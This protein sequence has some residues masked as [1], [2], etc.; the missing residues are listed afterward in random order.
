MPAKTSSKASSKGAAAAK[1]SES[2]ADNATVKIGGRVSLAQVEKACSAL[3]AHR[4]RSRTNAGGN[5]ASNDLPLDG[6]DDEE[7][8]GARSN[9]SDVVWMQI[10][11]KALN[12][13][14]PAKPIRLPTPYPIYAPS[15]SICLITA[16]PQRTYKDL[17]V[18]QKLTQVKRVVGVTKLK[19]KFAPYEARR[20]LMNDHDLFLAD[21]RIIPMLPKLLGKKWMN[22]RKSPIPVQL[23]KTKDGKVRKE[24]ESALASTFYHRNKGTCASVRLGTLQ[25]LTS[26]QLAENVAAAL[27]LIVSKHVKNGWSNVQS[28]DIKTGTSAALPVWNCD[29]AD[30][31]EGLPEMKES[32]EAKAKADKINKAKGNKSASKPRKRRSTG[33]EKDETPK[34]A[35]KTK[36]S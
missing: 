7:G 21:D 13:N 19:G 16:D 25:H 31:W 32:E 3:S 18:E 15:S 8:D 17:M 1:G 4:Q 27:P 28:I 35:A 24:V 5:G 33:S 6:E 22:E 20:Q 10:T 30:R 34:K 36:S 11:I 26:E 2:K 29:M 12:V 14:A 9:A 23:T